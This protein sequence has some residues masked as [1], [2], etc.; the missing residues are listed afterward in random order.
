M[1][2]LKEWARRG[3]M[4]MLS[5]LRLM[6]ITMRKLW[7]PVMDVAGPSFLIVY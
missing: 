3:S 4:R 1:K 6:I 7:L 2:L 5:T